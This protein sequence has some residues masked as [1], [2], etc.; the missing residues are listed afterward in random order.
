[1]SA[2]GEAN[3]PLDVV[4]KLR[5]RV[6]GAGVGLAAE[7]IASLFACD[8]G[9]SLAPPVLVIV[10]ADLADQAAQPRDVNDITASAGVNF[11]SRFLQ[12]AATLSV[13]PEL[14]S[15]LVE[16][17]GQLLA[18]DALIQ[19]TD[20]HPDKP[21]C[22]VYRNEIVPIDHE[23]AFPFLHGQLLP[24]PWMARGLEFLRTHVVFERLLGQLPS[25]DRIEANAAKITDER[26]A[27]YRAAIPTAWNAENEVKQATDFLMEL[28]PY[29]PH[30]L[31]ELRSMLR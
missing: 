26:L 15:W 21:N 19:N 12:P 9:I 27:S 8:L 6:H 14:P 20:R 16:E 28:R 2:I 1:M 30:V 7:L 10:E 4:V 13:G 5:A 3:A 11:G 23:L 22:L 25:F 24:Q 17:A 18:F 31:S 29:V